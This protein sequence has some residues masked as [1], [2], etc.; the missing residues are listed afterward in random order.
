MKMR[1]DSLQRKAYSYV[2]GNGQGRAWTIVFKCKYKKEDAEIIPDYE[3]RLRTV[4]RAVTMDA[5]GKKI[6]MEHQ[7]IK[8]EFSGLVKL[9]N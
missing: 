2:Q 8:L 7:D 1:H 5:Y 3:T 4:G 9:G 6:R